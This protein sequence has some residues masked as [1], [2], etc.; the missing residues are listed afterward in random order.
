MRDGQ[1]RKLKSSPGTGGIQEFLAKFEAKL[2]V[3]AGAGAG[4]EFILD[5]EMRT[6]GRGPGVDL[7]FD[8]PDMSRQHAVIEFAGGGFRV[9]DLGSTNGTVVN[10]A[11][12]QTAEL[13]HG[14][15]M[16]FGNQTL[17]LVIEE[18]ESM[19]ETYEL[20]PVG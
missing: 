6:I 19:P 2:V 17:Q 16:Q 5:Q 8:N 18:R 13:Q 7:A 20:P 15:R 1:T 4:T 3:V 12:A 14:D 11:P 10:G 9:R